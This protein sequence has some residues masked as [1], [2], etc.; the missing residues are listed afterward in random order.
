MTWL[1]FKS[2]AIAAA[3]A[4]V[5][6]GVS[7]ANAA[8]V[9]DQNNAPYPLGL[10]DDLEWQQQVTAGLS[11]EL[12]GIT[13]YGS[14]ASDFVQIA[15]GVGFY[16]GSYAF[17]QTVHLSP[18]GTFIDT[19]AANIMLAAGQTFV[20][21]VTQGQGCCTLAANPSH[22]AGGDLF[23]V[24]S[25]VHDTVFS[26]AFQSFMANGVPEPTTWALIVGGLSLTGAALRRRRSVV[27]T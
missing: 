10:N 18:G 3:L 15:Q 4:G 21:D 24:A 11:G 27:E 12:V 17:A 25:G 20:I 26:M 1:K 16:S 8:G 7:S 2:S 14:G 13:L 5:A 6:I 23:V 9:L 19:S 22:Y